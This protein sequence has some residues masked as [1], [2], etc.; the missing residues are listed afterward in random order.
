MKVYEAGRVE[1]SGRPV[2]YERR[3]EAEYKSRGILY[4]FL[5][6]E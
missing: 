6:V 5:P 4:Y 3:K 2:R 1:K